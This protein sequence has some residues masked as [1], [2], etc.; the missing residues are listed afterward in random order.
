[1]AELWVGTSGFA[2]KGWVG[3]FYPPGTSS[4]DMLNY[5]AG[6]F[7]TVE[8]NSTF[9]QFP[10][11]KNLSEWNRRVPKRFQ[12]SFKAHQKITHMKRLK[13]CDEE[14]R[15]LFD[16]LSVLGEHVGVVLFQLPPNAVW[17][18]E[19]FG[20]F[21]QTLPPGKRI[22]FEFRHKSWMAA[23]VYELL[24]RHGYGWC[25]A[26]TDGAPPVVEYT[27]GFAY[28]RLRK[29]VYKAAELKQWARLVAEQ[30][31]AGRSVYAYLKHEEKGEAAKYAQSL[32][33]YV[34][35]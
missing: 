17:H 3:H 5:Y 31:G 15:I 25:I 4:A 7:P 20:S 19:V 34:A 18:P 22:A 13:G 14:V 23:P 11:A 28:L 9:Y 27:S 1:M 16:N 35:S 21:L 32:L 30:L 33:S 2:Y 26:E 10:R 8:I 24:T 12:F 6:H 29:T